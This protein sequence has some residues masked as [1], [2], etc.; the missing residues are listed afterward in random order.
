MIDRFEGEN[1]FLSN[2]Y[3]ATVTFEGEEYPT[4]E[5]AYQAAKTID[6][7]S[8]G[9]IK[10]CTTPG[11]AKRMGAKVG[12]RQDWEVIKESV[13]LDLLRQKFQNK[14]LSQKLL[15]TGD[16]DLVEG[17]NWGDCEW[18]VCNGIGKNKLGKI[19]M[20]VRLERKEMPNFDFNLKKTSKIV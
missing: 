20:Q 14:E 8:R 16:Q 2:F 19:L 1:F 13:M 15:E 11:R 5:H 6:N 9:Q 12:L 17:N 4:T 3:P 7:N 18:G 10:L